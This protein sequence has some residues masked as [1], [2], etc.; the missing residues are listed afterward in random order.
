MENITQFFRNLKQDIYSAKT[1]K[2]LVILE[3]RAR[4]FK[5]EYANNNTIKNDIK[6]SVNKN[7]IKSLK[8][9]HKMKKKVID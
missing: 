9:I 3:K 2:T 5:E 8:L 6:R 4:E 1:K 7:Y